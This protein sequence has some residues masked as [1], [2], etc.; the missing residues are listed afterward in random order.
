[1][2]PGGYRRQSNLALP[3]SMIFVLILVILN[4]GCP[5]WCIPGYVKHVMAWGKSWPQEGNSCK[6]IMAA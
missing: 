2:R 5:S 1:V 3:R 6:K 4:V